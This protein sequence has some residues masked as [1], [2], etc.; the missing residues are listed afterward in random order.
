MQQRFPNLTDF[1]GNLVLPNFLWGARK[2]DNGLTWEPSLLARTRT[3]ANK[4]HPIERNVLLAEFGNVYDSRNSCANRRSEPIPR[5]KTLWAP[6][7]SV[8]KGRIPAPRSHTG[9]AVSLTSLPVG[10][11]I[12]L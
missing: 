7:A 11:T 9:V 3:L 2:K 1:L 4:P 12:F 6:N 8:R 5:C 10:P